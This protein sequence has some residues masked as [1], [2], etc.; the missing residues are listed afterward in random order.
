MACPGCSRPLCN[1]ISGLACKINAGRMVVKWGKKTQISIVPRCSQS[2]PARLNQRACSWH[3]AD[4]ETEVGLSRALWL[5]R[6]SAAWHK[7]RTAKRSLER[8]ERKLSA[9]LFIKK[10]VGLKDQLDRPWMDGI[11]SKAPG[12]TAGSPEQTLDHLEWSNSK[13]PQCTQAI[14]SVHVT[15]KQGLPPGLNDPSWMGGI[16]SKA[17]GVPA[18]SFHENLGYLEWSYRKVHQGPQ[19]GGCPQHPHGACELKRSSKV[20]QAAFGKTGGHW[21]ERRRSSTGSGGAHGLWPGE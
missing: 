2:G 11:L 6:E 18:G 1:W 4:S 9:S 12:R 8:Q 13:V 14:C 15:E 7:R 17:P 20:Q 3:M 19:A 10:E 16:P 21:P 5:W